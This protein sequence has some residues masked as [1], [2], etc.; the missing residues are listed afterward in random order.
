M[1]S[2][3]VA[4]VLSGGGKMASTEIGML[5]A[6]T[7]AGIRP[8]FVLGSSA[9]A[10]IGAVF[11]ERAD[12][13]ALSPAYECWTEILTAPP[14]RWSVPRGLY[15]LLS[16]TARQEAQDCLGSIIQ[17]HTAARTFEELAVHYECNAVRLN[18]LREHW[19]D[20]GPLIPAVLSAGAAPGIT[21][22]A[23]VGGHTYFDG[24]FLDPI[25]LERALQLGARTVYILQTTDFSQESRFPQVLW[26]AGVVEGTFRLMFNSLLD[27]LPEGTEVH[28][29]PIGRENPSHG[30]NLLRRVYGFDSAHARGEGERYMEM[31]Y[32]A[33]AAYLRFEGQVGNSAR[34]RV[35]TRKHE[36]S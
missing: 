22:Y 8:D 20:S 27:D 19:F 34:K 14:L 31:A 18:T 5:V 15:R 9:G 24:G 28:L 26:R 4:F 2:G 12:T 33:T 21:S 25:P 16:P 35:G 17:R 11:A 1:A 3:P 30:L 13:S 23:K 7:E 29:L 10:M 6:L 36:G 32:Q